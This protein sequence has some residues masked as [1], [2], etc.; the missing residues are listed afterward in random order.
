VLLEKRPQRDLRRDRRVHGGEE[1]TRA[2]DRVE[3]STP[4]YIQ[5]CRS[6]LP[7]RPPATIPYGICFACI[8]PLGSRLPVESCSSRSLRWRLHP[9]QVSLWLKRP[10]GAGRET[11][12]LIVMTESVWRR[13]SG[14]DEKESRTGVQNS[15]YTADPNRA[16]VARPTPATV[17]DTLDSLEQQHSFATAFGIH[18]RLSH[19]LRQLGAERAD[20]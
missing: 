5:L 2:R 10:G 8:A 19:S 13:M 9:K 18:R 12:R 11:A 7:L 16:P 15:I 1:H 17:S 4:G 6:S 3:V 20:R 14:G